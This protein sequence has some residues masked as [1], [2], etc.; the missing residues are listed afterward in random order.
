MLERL[1]INSYTSVLARL[2]IYQ[3]IISRTCLDSKVINN[4]TDGGRIK[5]RFKATPHANAGFSGEIRSLRVR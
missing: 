2:M 5:E 3:I 1:L 4:Y